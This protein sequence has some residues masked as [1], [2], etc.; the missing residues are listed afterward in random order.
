MFKNCFHLFALN[1]NVLFNKTTTFQ[2]VKTLPP[3][4]GDFACIS[5]MQIFLCCGSYGMDIISHDTA[6]NI[7]Y[8]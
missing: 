5:K 2:N 1:F 7:L 3:K 4:M 8:T 6:T